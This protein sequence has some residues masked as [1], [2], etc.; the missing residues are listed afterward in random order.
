M[1][2]HYWYVSSTIHSQ[3]IAH[4]GDVIRAAIAS[5]ITSL[6]IVYSTVYSD[7][8]QRKHQSSASLAFVRGIHRGPVNSPHKWPVT[9][10]KFP[11]D[12]VIMGLMMPYSIKILVNI[13]AGH[14]LLPDG[15]RPLPEL[16]LINH[17]WGLVIFTWGQLQ[18]QCSWYYPWCE[19][20]SS[21]RISRQFWKSEQVCISVF[22]S[23]HF[24]IYFFV[25]IGL[26]VQVHQMHYEKKSNF[27]V[28]MT[29]MGLKWPNAFLPFSHTWPG[30][31]LPLCLE[32][33]IW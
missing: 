4:Y 24:S 26:L 32:G 33:A 29:E 23:Q 25:A 30:Y 15:A 2:L 31:G 5:Q 18:R 21:Q 20:Q 7:A 17:R 27:P 9:R 11:F 10:K 3:L 22:N 1:S 12:D 6:T 13:D 14:G 28:N 16:M 8:D 19:F